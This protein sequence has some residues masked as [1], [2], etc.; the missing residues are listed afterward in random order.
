MYISSS[1]LIY[2]SYIWKTYLNLKTKMKE[3]DGKE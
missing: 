1:I 3:G 2:K